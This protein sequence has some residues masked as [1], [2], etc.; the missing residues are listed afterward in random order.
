MVIKKIQINTRKA[1]P[2]FL[3][4][5]AVQPIVAVIKINEPAATIETNNA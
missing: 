1:R 2:W 3:E 5:D 4:L